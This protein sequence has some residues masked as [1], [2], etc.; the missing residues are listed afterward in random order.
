MA[1]D[2]LDADWSKIRVEQAPALPG[3]ANSALIQGFASEFGGG[4]GDK[5]PEALLSMIA[6][7]INSPLQD[8]LESL[9]EPVLGRI[10]AAMPAFAGLDLSPMWAG[11][12]IQV[13]LILLR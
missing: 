6:P 10:R 12:I 13:L 8:L 1:A 9:C 4:I 7:G 2:E 5:M 3:F 11:I